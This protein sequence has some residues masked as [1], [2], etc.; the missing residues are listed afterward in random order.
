MKKNVTTILI[1]FFI[2]NASYSFSQKKGE[3][4]MIQATTIKYTNSD[5][6]GAIEIVA[7]EGSQ[8]FEYSI[9]AGKTF[10]TKNVFENLCEGKYFIQVK[11]ATGKLGLTLV[12]VSNNAP[13]E[14]N[15]TPQT[16]SEQEIAALLNE[17]NNNM[18]NW[19]VRREIEHKISKYGH[20]YPVQI[21]EVVK[22]QSKI[23]YKYKMLTSSSITIENA[24]MM[25]ER[26]KISSEFNI[27]EIYF[28]SEKWECTVIFAPNTSID[29]INNYFVTNLFS[30]IN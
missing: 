9:D 1:L 27:I 25:L 7:L 30:G 24:K 5:C 17:R 26:Y 13:L 3:Q 23:M 8:P 14:S 19:E 12:E 20:K 4:L 6:N 18:D 10:L 16:L 22:D 2:L 28:D 29:V 21:I 15:F 11:D